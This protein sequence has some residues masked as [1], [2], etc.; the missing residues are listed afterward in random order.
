MSTHPTS[1]H[2]SFQLL[3]AFI[4]LLGLALPQIEH[5]PVALALDDPRATAG[6]WGAVLNWGIFGKH[7]AMMP[8]GKVL[9][10]P[11]GQ[12][13]FVWDPVTQTKTAV[14]A[15]FGDLHCA[16]QTFLADGRV[17]VA[18]GVIVSPHDGITVTAIFDP[19]TNLWTNATPMHYPRWYGTTTRLAD[20]RILATSGDM[21]DGGRANIPEIYD[22][23]SDTWTLMP[24]SASKDLGLYPQMFTLPNGKAFAAGTKTNTYLLDINSASWAN[25][26]TNAFGSS[27]YAESSAMFA[28]GK[29]IR[30]GGADPAITKTA[31][32]DMT[33]AGPQWKQVP[34]MHFPRRRHNM[35]ILADGQVMAVGGTRRADDVGDPLTSP[36]AVYEGEIWNPATEQW[37]VTAPMSV[38]RMYHAAAVLL[39]DGRVLAAGGEYAGRYTAQIFSPPYLFK[40]ARPALSSAPAVASYGASF[41]VGVEISDGSTIQGVALIGLA[42][43]THAFDHNQ[44]YVPLS[45]SQAGD[46]LQVTA[47]PSAG[48]APPGYYML[49][50]VDSKGVPS[51]ATFIRVDTTANLVPGAISGIVTDSNG[52]PL[53][54]VSVSYPGGSTSTDSEGNYELSNITPGEVLVTFAKSGLATI[55]RSQQVVGGTTATLNVTLSPPGTISGKVTNSETGSGIGGAIVT[56][57]G[58]T[59]VADAGGNYSIPGI[60][61]GSQT[62]S[63]SATG[64]VSSADQGVTVPANGTVTAN[65]ALTPKPTFVAGEVR[66]SVTNELLAGASVTV[67][68]VTVQTDSTGR[69]QLF[70]GPGN[71]A[72]TV[73]QPGYKSFTKPEVVV[74]FGSYTAVDPILEPLFPPLFLGPVADS[75][76]GAGSPTTNYGSNAAL[77]INGG[78]SPYTAYLRF[79]VG[80]LTSKVQSAKLRLFVTD[81]SAKVGSLYLV[82][83]HFKDGSAPWTEAGLNWNNAPALGS[84]ALITGTGAAAQGGWVEFDVTA[85]VQDNGEYS[86]ALKTSAT[87]TLRYSSREGANPPQLIVKPTGQPLTT[88]G[89]FTPANG[90]AGTLVTI[91]GTGLG[92]VTGVTFNGQPAASITPVSSSELRAVVPGGASTGKIGLVTPEGTLNSAGDF[93]VVAVVPALSISGFSPTVGSAGTEVTIN[94]AGFS[95]ITGLLFNGKPASSFTLI[96]LTEIKAIVPAGASTGKITISTT[97]KQVQSAGSFVVSS[98]PPRLVFIPLARRPAS[99]GAATYSAQST[100]WQDPVASSEFVCRQGPE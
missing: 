73:T 23:I 53:S 55:K 65:I 37:S 3:F 34:G 10:W 97:G 100:G 59:V 30:S 49:V 9:A 64:Y 33:A 46:T 44:R 20:G 42:A 90:P 43:V 99:A 75:Y 21:P 92:R 87:D 81:A 74:T 7:M 16:A 84:T 82:S 83:N 52:D 1:Y 45:F 51:V 40:G 78:S 14:P 69:Y 56:Y 70:I 17:I 77:R 68:N 80:G 91:S 32:I 79:A 48:H 71:Y 76:V 22:P 86:F 24:A 63:A 15:N 66:D 19:A 41:N 29:I 72:M 36:G 4:L 89:G 11:T 60:P 85:A 47:P 6:E 25:G 8:N 50:V 39:P 27:G 62:L 95:G 67:G 18:G 98:A 54:G 31:T 94:G 88:F 28:P 57:L 93:H 13:A 5:T 38:D 12:D 35:V 61:A 58:G 96:S 2:R 26:P